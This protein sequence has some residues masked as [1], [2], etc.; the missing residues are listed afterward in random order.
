MELDKRPNNNLQ[1]SMRYL[2]ANE[3]FKIFI[4]N[5]KIYE[6]T[7]K[8][9]TPMHEDDIVLDI[10]LTAIPQDN[11]ISIKFDW[12]YNN[13]NRVFGLCIREFVLNEKK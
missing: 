3:P 1:L 13:V 9:F 5:T 6:N 7:T 8:N 12:P 11:K 2:K 10:P 4:N